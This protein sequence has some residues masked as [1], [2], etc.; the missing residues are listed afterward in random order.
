MAE[1]RDGSIGWSDRNSLMAQWR[2]GAM[3]QL[4]G[5]IEIH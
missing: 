1:W 5:L 3:A 4:G 2:D